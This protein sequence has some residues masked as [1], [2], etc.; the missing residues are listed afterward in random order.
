MN[1]TSRSFFIISILLISFVFCSCGKKAD[2]LDTLKQ[3]GT[4]ALA[5]GNFNKAIN[6]FRDALRLRPSD[7][8]ILYNLALSYK[9]F[10]VPDSALVYFRRARLLYPRDREINKELIELC[11]A[12]KEYECALNAVAIMIATGDNEKLYWPMLAELH[13]RN[14]DMYMAAKYYRLIL[15]DDPDNSSAY[16]YLATTLSE[17]SNYAESNQIIEKLIARFGPSADAFA[18]MAANFA[19]MNQ[20]DKA[21]EFLRKSLAINP[22]YIPAWINLANLLAADSNVARKKEALDILKRF[23]SQIPAVY[24]PDSVI[25]ALEAELSGK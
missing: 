16:L 10:D 6:L 4:K 3:E 12:A 24:K 13:Y 21:E 18:N 17:T 11:I 23:Q 15:A 1:M 9:K 8:D 2:D 14:K 22:D 19:N 25:S 5:D 20:L 7:R